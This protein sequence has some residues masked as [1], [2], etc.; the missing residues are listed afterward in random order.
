MGNKIYN[1][2]VRLVV[3]R[4]EVVEFE[5]SGNEKL[6]QSVSEN[7]IQQRFPEQIPSAYE[8]GPVGDFYMVKLMETFVKEPEVG[9]DL[10]DMIAPGMV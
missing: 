6:L 3:M 2:T 9:V 4:P 1:G 7:Y 10:N 8:D 5:F